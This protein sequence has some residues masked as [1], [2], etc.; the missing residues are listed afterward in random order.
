MRSRTATRYEVPSTSRQTNVL[1]TCQESEMKRTMAKLDHL[2]ADAR[3][4]Q[5]QCKQNGAVESQAKRLTVRAFG[6]RVFEIEAIG[7][8]ERQQHEQAGDSNQNRRQQRRDHHLGVK[9]P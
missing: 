3:P 7:E 9:I 2:A 8:P 4:E 1:S 6:R 5:E